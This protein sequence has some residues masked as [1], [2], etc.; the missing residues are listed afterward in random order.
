MDHVNC[1]RIGQFLLTLK[2]WSVRKFCI[3]LRKRMRFTQVRMGLKRNM[4]GL[5]YIDVYLCTIPYLYCI[6]RSHGHFFLTVR[7]A[8][9]NPI[10][11]THAA[12]EIICTFECQN[13]NVFYHIC[14][15][16]HSPTLHLC[17]C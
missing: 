10:V 15:F 1:S 2:T 6:K 13:K 8:A 4:S 9:Q 3:L 7:H 5:F 12:R 17:V 11:Y 16:F 14:G